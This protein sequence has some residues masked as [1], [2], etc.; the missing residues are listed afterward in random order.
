MLLQLL[1]LGN[2]SGQLGIVFIKSLE[3][4]GCGVD[5]GLPYDRSS[6]LQSQ[7]EGIGSETEKCHTHPLCPT[8]LW[9]VWSFTAGHHEAK[10]LAVIKEGFP[11]PW[12]KQEHPVLKKD[13]N[14]AFSVGRDVAQGQSPLE[15]AWGEQIE[16]QCWVLPVPKRGSQSEWERGPA[17]IGAPGALHA[18][19]AVGVSLERSWSSQNPHVHCT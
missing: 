14:C 5:G 18:G 15:P 11:G 9:P 12:D 13:S 3:L 19:S 16:L 2:L 6:S 7:V 1:L 17:C 4:K 8:L 10:I